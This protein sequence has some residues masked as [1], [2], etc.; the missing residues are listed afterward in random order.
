MDGDLGRHHNVLQLIS[1]DLSSAP[2]EST[3]RNANSDGAISNSNGWILRKSTLKA[4]KLLIVDCPQ[5]SRTTSSGGEYCCSDGWLLINRLYSPYG[6]C[7]AVKPP[8][9]GRR[10]ARQ[11]Y[12]IRHLVALLGKYRS[13]GLTSG[14]RGAATTS[15]NKLP[16]TSRSHHLNLLIE[17]HRLTE[18][19]QNLMVGS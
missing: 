19:F 12:N 2:S 4:R 3:H 11:N 10:Q 15:F 7:L 18:R 14:D 1:W 9:L 6:R 5:F 16:G 8:R 17:I 13:F